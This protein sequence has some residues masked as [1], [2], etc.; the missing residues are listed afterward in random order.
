VVAGVQ[1]AERHKRQR[2]V[3]FPLGYVAVAWIYGKLVKNIVPISLGQAQKNI[4]PAHSRD[5]KLEKSL[6]AK[7]E[8]QHQKAISRNERAPKL[9][10][11]PP[12]KNIIPTILK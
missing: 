10:A 1:P 12:Q 4:I 9:A 11:H 8:I 6:T 3:R 7:R 5:G 2:T